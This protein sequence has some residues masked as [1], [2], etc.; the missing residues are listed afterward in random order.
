MS[1]SKGGREH[2]VCYPS[3]ET[4][5]AQPPQDEGGGVG[6]RKT[7]GRYAFFSAS[8][9]RTLIGVPSSQASMSLIVPS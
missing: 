4:A 6:R 2:Y 1:V 8:G 5:A 7:E 9:L 3:F